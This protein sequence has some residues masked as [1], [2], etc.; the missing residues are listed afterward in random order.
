MQ[1]ERLTVETAIEEDDAS[2]DASTRR[3]IQ[4]ERLMHERGYQTP[5]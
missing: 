5:G 1:S 4:I 2:I 3:L